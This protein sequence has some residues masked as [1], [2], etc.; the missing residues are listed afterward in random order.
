MYVFQKG[1][2]GRADIEDGAKSKISSVWYTVPA[3]VPGV[4]KFLS[5]VRKFT[6]FMYFEI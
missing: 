6:N 3:P 2:L 5:F 1:A 4:G